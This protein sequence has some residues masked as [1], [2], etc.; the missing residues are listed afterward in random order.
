MTG[1]TRLGQAVTKSD[2]AN[3][4]GGKNCF[5]FPGRGRI[6]TNVPGRDKLFPRCQDVGRGKKNGTWEGDGG[7]E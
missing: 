4:W 3:L 7:D 1:E 5:Q 6:G 2:Y